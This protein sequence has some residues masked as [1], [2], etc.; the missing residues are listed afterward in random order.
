MHMNKKSVMKAKARLKKAKVKLAVFQ[1]RARKEMAR[2]AVALKTHQ[3]AAKLAARSY[4]RA[5]KS[6]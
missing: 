1:R 4:K 2:M 5:L 3:R 6:A